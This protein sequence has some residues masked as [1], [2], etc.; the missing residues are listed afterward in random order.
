MVERKY[1]YEK[2]LDGSEKLRRFLDLYKNKPSTHRA[3]K[4]HLVRYFQY[5]GIDDIDEYVK[6]TR[7]LNEDK[8]IKYLDAIENDLKK[9]WIELNEQTN[10][11]TPYIWLSAMKM[12]L[13]TNKTF[14]LDDVFL[15]MQKNGHGNYAI[16]NTR[17]PTKEELLKIFSYSNPESKALFMFQLTSGQRLEEVIKTTYENIDMTKDFPRIYYPKSK[18]KNS[19]KTRIT[20]EAKHFLEQY[21]EQRDKF[22]TIRQERGGFNRKTKIDT[23]RRIFPMTEGNAEQIWAIMVKNAGLYKLDPITQKPE[24]GTHCLRRYFLSHF[25]DREW[26]DFFSGH[27]TQRS[28]E[29]RQYPDEKLDEEYSKHKD[30]LLIFEKIPDLTDINHEMKELKQEN[31]KLKKDMEEMKMKLLELLVNKH[32]EQINGKK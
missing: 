2:Y 22:I 26:G 15:S 13:I 31:E 6:D 30:D 5:M 3:Y 10:G 24:F 21:L 11:K 20:P 8:K 17:T 9:Y 14:E 29:Y 7:R 19:I 12:F 23:K 4:L 25:S 18:T 28:K 32:E 27:I 1:D 16:T